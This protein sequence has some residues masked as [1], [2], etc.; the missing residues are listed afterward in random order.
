[1]E[2]PAEIWKWIDANLVNWF[3]MLWWFTG[4]VFLLSTYARWWVWGRFWKPNI[5]ET[6]GA[7]GWGRVLALG[8]TSSWWGDWKRLAARFAV[9]GKEVHFVTAILAS[10]VLPVYAL[11]IIFAFG[12]EYLLVYIIGAAM[13]VPLV[14]LGGKA[15]LSFP[16]D[17]HAPRTPSPERVRFWMAPVKELFGVAPRFLYGVLLAGVL[18]AVA[19]HP[20]WTFP[21]E[22]TGAGVISQLLNALFGVVLAVGA[23]TPPVGAFLLGVPVWRGGFALAGLIAFLLAVPAAPQA[24]M[25][26]AEWLGRKEAAKLAV[27]ILVAA[28]VSAVATAVVASLL[29][30]QLPYL[31]APDQLLWVNAGG[32]AQ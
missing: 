12:K 17:D 29:G 28:V 23:W 4:L 21:V 7:L 30:L 11:L 24:V 31:Y 10:H 22:I 26:Y 3:V 19:I 9:R 6:S 20:E 15:I 18:A 1:M 8:I 25:T 5:Q 13:F 27:V 14:V 16:E 2:W 32:G